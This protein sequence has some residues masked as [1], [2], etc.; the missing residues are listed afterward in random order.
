MGKANENKNIKVITDIRL[1]QRIGQMYTLLQTLSPLADS[2]AARHIFS[3]GRLAQE[4]RRSGAD[5]A[6]L[7][8]LN[9]LTAHGE[10]WSGGGQKP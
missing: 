4:E 1:Y 8:L 9:L 5:Y 7:S 2:R 10:G 3:A 6:N